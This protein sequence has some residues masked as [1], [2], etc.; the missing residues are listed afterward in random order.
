MY[1]LIL[2]IIVLIIADFFA[3][4]GSLAPKRL[5]TLVV[6]AV[7]ISVTYH[8]SIKSYDIPTDNPNGIIKH[9]ARYKV[10]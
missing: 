6:A 8:V 2:F 7:D 4:I 9:Q 10:R 3:R 5:P 1:H